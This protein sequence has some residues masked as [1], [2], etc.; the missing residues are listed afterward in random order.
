MRPSRTTNIVTVLFLA[1]AVVGHEWKCH[2][3]SRRFDLSGYDVSGWCDLYHQGDQ[4]IDI[5]GIQ[6]VVFGTGEELLTSSVA[7]LPETLLPGQRL[8]GTFA[9]RADRSLERADR[10]VLRLGK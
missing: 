8:R 6:I 4:P 7:G 10:V 3:R 1:F 5:A 2:A 9:L